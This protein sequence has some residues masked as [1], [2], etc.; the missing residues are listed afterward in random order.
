MTLTSPPFTV[1]PTDCPFCAPKGV[2]HTGD[3]V[4]GL[5]DAF[6]ATPGHAL[7]VTKAHVPTWFDASEAERRE[8]SSATLAARAEILRV[9][10]DVTGFNVGVN[11]HASGGQ[12][13]PHLHVHVI[14]RRD[15]DVPD[16]R[17]G[18]RNVIPGKGLYGSMRKSLAPPRLLSTGGKE[19]LLPEL[20]HELESARE[21]DV[22][23]AFVMSSGVDHLLPHFEQ[24]LARG[25]ALRL[26]TGDYLDITDPTA[27]RRLLDLR[28]EYPAGRLELRVFV[29]AGTSFHPKAYILRDRSTGAGAAFVGSS[30]LSASALREGVEWNYRVVPA[31]DGEGF[32]QVCNAFEALFEHPQTRV[33]DDEWVSQYEARRRIAPIDLPAVAD[34][35]AELLAPPPPPH[36]V[37]LEA[38]AALAATR[39]TGFRAGLVVMATG[40]GKTWLSA[41]D[42]ERFAR[43][44]FVAHREEILTQA[45]HTYRR[46]RPSASFGR[47]DGGEKVRRADVTFASVQTLG[48]SKHLETF[49]RGAFDYIVMDEFHHASAATYRRIIDYFEPRFLLGLTAT[50]ERT[51]GGDLLA[52]CQENLVYSC[53]I[54]AGIN[55][56]LLAPFAY[57]GVPDTIDYS[58]TNIP[59]LSTHFD[60]EALTRAAATTTRAQNVL[61]QWRARG[62]R[63]TLAFCVS[64]RHADF[65]REFFTGAGVKVATVHSGPG[66]DPR[67]SSLDRL[68]SG[69]LEIIFSV[70]M[71]NEGVDVP[72][73]DTVMMLRPTE[74]AI[75][76]L[77]QFGRGLRTQPGKTLKVIDY[78]GNHRTFLLKART[79][80][81]VP[82]GSDRELNAA[83]QR[84]MDQEFELPPGCSITYELEAVNIMRA[85]LRLP[86]T[87]RDALREYYIDFRE[88]RGVRPTAMEA[89]H[90]G[91]NPRS[92]ETGWFGLVEELGDLSP[93]QVT[94]LTECRA[95]LDS[96]A[97]TEMS[98]SYK[99]VLLLALL[100]GD[101]IPGEG[102]PISELVTE[103]RRFVERD[104]RLR[105]D[106]K[107]PLEDL[108]QLIE[109]NPIDAWVGAKGTSAAFF[110]Y[111]ANVFRFL[112][113]VS[114]RS[115][116]QELIRELAELRL[117]M[118]LARL[119]A[120]A[121]DQFVLNVSHVDKKPMIFLPSRK[122]APKLPVDWVPLTI[123]GQK[124]DGNFVKIA[125]NVVREQGKTANELPRVLRKWFGADAGLPG[126][127][128]KVVLSR[129]LG[130]WQLAPLNPA[131]PA[132]L[133]KWV[134]YT[135]EQIPELLG[136]T[137]SE[138]IW[139]VGFVVRPNIKSPKQMVLLVTLGKADMHGGFKFLDQFRSPSEF[140]WQ[141]QNQTTQKSNPGQLI[142]DHVKRGVA[143]HLFVRKT[144][145]D[146]KGSAAP[147]IYCGPVTF[148]SWDGEKPINV[149]WQLDTPLPDRIFEKLRPALKRE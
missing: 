45:L 109:K 39:A 27:L 135:R 61:E 58:P 142:R 100:N 8:I 12:T 42:S 31:R 50:P 111:K 92:R 138:A 68:A 73:V 88:R 51:D 124:F 65:M 71:F 98:K 29:S 77:Q 86:Q 128:H 5:W 130:E 34:A 26:V 95:F 32:A 96:L 89:F 133:E 63:R 49:E 21:V 120:T 85:L 104:P 114:A 37:Q 74:S 147:F 43:V 137:F 15:K 143:V 82:A 116:A 93:A 23:V 134:Q 66:S 16:A 28:L 67:Q 126:T 52:L 3:L 38:L 4:L 59:W 103:F 47:F 1:P 69:D 13:V 84:V 102:L 20:A 36:E 10:S 80:L 97:K 55:Q 18:V 33:L 141:S 110:S 35:E 75:V 79:L 139:N 54:A 146:A 9:H 108:R 22:A 112:P 76:W 91:Y 25:G 72:T 121:E 119:G 132:A 127:S 70:D 2:F 149:R 64:Q 60:E 125:L 131:K 144:K 30:N 56:G 118:Y 136:E 14:P 145:K 53:G 17:G 148:Q 24:L 87:D 117:A 44:L 113:R 40:L 6:P 115:E 123:E 78:I 46:V 57:Y 11:V 41:F 90:D 140:D 107:V 105:N 19:P 48:R 99:M 81:E 7:V 83:L 106:V 129:A 62:G 122:Q 101:G 94:A